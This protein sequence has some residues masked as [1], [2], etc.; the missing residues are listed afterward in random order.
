MKRSTC[1]FTFV[2]ALLLMSTL[3]QAQVFEIINGLRYLIDTENKEA[4]L[5]PNI[6]VYSGDIVVPE[7][8]AYNGYEY[9]VVSFW[10]YCFD[11]C[12]GLTSITIPPTVRSLGVGCFGNC[13]GLSSITIPSSVTT[14]ENSCFHGCS[15]LTTLFIPSS[16]DSIGICCFYG[17]SGLK[18]VTIQ[19]SVK[20]LGY[21]CFG[22]CSELTSITIPP[23]VT[24][25]GY[26]CFHSCT[27]LTSIDIPP[28]VTS[29]GDGCF[30]FCSELKSITIPSSVTSIGDECFSYCPN[31]T[32]ITCLATI[33]PNSKYSFKRYEPENC[34]LYVQKPSINKY[35]SADGWYLFPNIYA[36]EKSIPGDITKKCEVPSITYTNGTLHFASST[37]GAE[38]FY[39]IIDNNI[40]NNVYDQSD[41]FP[42]YC[43]YQISAY[44][45]AEDYLDSDTATAILYWLPISGFD[46]IERTSSRGIVAT[47][48]NRIITISGLSAQEKVMFYTVT[49]EQLGSATAVDNTA[50]YAVN[51]TGDVI[52][53]KLRDFSIK[54]AT[55]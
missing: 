42:L 37:S 54:I 32:S 40:A 26:S 5:V 18:S 43:A 11:N 6:P 1:F 33:P 50:T 36:I 39:T 16:V 21:Y 30:F 14:L 23:S 45:T 22:G 12:F 44:A 20:Y 15:G 9:P 51:T 52:I 41:E 24:T 4:H 25:L 38:Y 55:K 10:K 2:F 48:N 53:A 17:C 28:S 49:G 8:I 7:K 29:L 35:K 13:S 3:A 31:L 47:C 34:K 27:K 19:A 46:N